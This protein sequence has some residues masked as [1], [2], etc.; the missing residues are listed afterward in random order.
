MVP[1]NEKEPDALVHVNESTQKDPKLKKKR[2]P[3][4]EEDIYLCCDIC[5][6]EFN[7]VKQFRK[8]ISSHSNRIPKRMLQNKNDQVHAGS[9]SDK[10][11]NEKI[12]DEKNKD[13]NEVISNENEKVRR[14]QGGI[15][16][17][18]IRIV[19]ASKKK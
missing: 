1:G 9:S 15:F 17:R 8:H 4:G 13:L 2:Y 14:I 12:R 3:L 6:M 5:S 10:I 19:S 18:G 16:R 11:N 7:N